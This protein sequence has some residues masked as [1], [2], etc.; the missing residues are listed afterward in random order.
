MPIGTLLA[1]TQAM[2]QVL[3]SIR[4][5]GTPLEALD[6]LPAF[7]DFTELIGVSEIEALEADYS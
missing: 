5:H 3:A 4:E 2:Q 7:G 6:Q 1:A